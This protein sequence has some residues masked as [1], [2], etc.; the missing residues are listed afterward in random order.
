MTESCV[1]PEFTTSEVA[2]I[3]QRLFALEG[4][5]AQLNGERDLNFLFTDARGKFVFKITNTL[6]SPA[7][8]ECQH[9]VFQRLAR[10]QVFPLVATALESI[11]GR[12]IETLRDAHG[13]QHYCRALP[14]LEGR[15]WTDLAESSP[16]LLA[17]LGHRLALLD[18]ALD[19]FTHPGLERPLLWNMETAL[20][21]LEAYKPLLTTPD[22]RKLVEHFEHGFRERVLP[23]RDNLRRAVIH[24][25]ANRENVIVDE[26][27][28]RVISIIDF[29]DMLH[30]WLVAEP[31]I[32]TA[33]AMLDSKHPL[34]TA[35]ALLGG[36][37]ATLPLEATEIGLIFDL[38][39]MRLCMSVC[40]CAHQRRLQPDNE[41]LSIDERQCWD[42]L[43]RLQEIAPL[44]FSDAL[45]STCGL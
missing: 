43:G 6:E 3:A 1:L 34:A 27:G 39:C 4:M 22:Q 30:L 24:N 5:T 15:M 18:R 20:P 14:F 31:A 2:E 10:A 16:A 17:D 26:T 21:V 40:I 28:S 42:L 45:L 23:H 29:G 11:N 37:H 38:A 32:A 7:M 35:Q 9:L 36:Y 41:Y 8:L 44:N 33:Y 12:S 19:S 13:N 25:D